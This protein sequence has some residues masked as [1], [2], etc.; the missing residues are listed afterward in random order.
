[1]PED[2]SERVLRLPFFTDLTSDDQT[3]VI[4][5]VQSFVPAVV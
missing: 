1:L 2:V 4:E 5:T 3:S